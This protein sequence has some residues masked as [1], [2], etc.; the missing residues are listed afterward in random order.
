MTPLAPRQ[1]LD[2]TP[3]WR[4]M[5]PSA[6]VQASIDRRRMKR[7]AVLTAKEDFLKK[8]HEDT[9]QLLNEKKEDSRQ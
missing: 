8:K 9:E 4:R 3:D 7:E 2:T 6:R 1:I 5:S